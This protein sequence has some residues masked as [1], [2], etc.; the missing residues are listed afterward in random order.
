MRCGILFHEHKGVE[1]KSLL[2]VEP[3][4]G[5]TLRV[6]SRGGKHP[7]PVLRLAWDGKTLQTMTKWSPD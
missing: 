6:M 3:E 1:D 4:F 5:S 7:S 2:V